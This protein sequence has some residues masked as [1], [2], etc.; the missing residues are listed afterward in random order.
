[1]STSYTSIAVEPDPEDGRITHLRLDAPERNNTI[2][3]RMLREFTDAVVAAD[4]DP[5]VRGVVLGATG[6]TFCAGASLQELT[7]LTVEEGARWM[8]AYLEALELLRDTGK[9]VVAAVEGVCAAGGNEL[10]SAC[11][12]IVAGESARFGQPEVGVGS[13]AAGGG[14]QLL[15]LIV[16]EKRARDLLLT[17]RML[18]AEEARAIG[19]INRVVEDG[20]AEQR[21]TALVGKIL[22]RNSPQAYRTIK[23]VMKQWTNVGLAGGEMARDLTAHVW[24]SEEFRERADAFLAR[25]DQQPRPFTGTRPPA[26]SD[27]DDGDEDE[28][29]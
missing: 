2:D 26:G 12:L 17:G 28:D 7:D 20:T 4:R 21:A 5:E 15:P 10:V 25:E 22:D 27:D 14:A 19:L 23:A 13:T 1:M 3:S 11:D 24:A 18:E 9:P 16:G 8:T 6:E 29:G